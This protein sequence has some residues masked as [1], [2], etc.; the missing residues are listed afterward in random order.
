MIILAFCVAYVVTGLVVG[1]VREYK[2]G[3]HRAKPIPGYTDHRYC[4]SWACDIMTTELT[5]LS[6]ALWPIAIPIWMIL[7]LMSVFRKAG[8]YSQMPPENECEG[9]KVSP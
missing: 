6:I 8:G 5:V 2:I 3:A 7:N 1:C 4:C 9:R